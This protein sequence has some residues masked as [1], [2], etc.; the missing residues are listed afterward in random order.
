MFYWNGHT[1]TDAVQDRV[2]AVPV[3]HRE[4]WRRFKLLRRRVASQAWWPRN[5]S[6]VRCFAPSLPGLPR[7]R[8]PLLLYWIRLKTLALGPKAQPGLGLTR[9][10]ALNTSTHAK[11]CPNSRFLDEANSSRQTSFVGLINPNNRCLL[12]KRTM[13]KQQSGDEWMQFLMRHACLYSSWQATCWAAA[14][15]MKDK[16]E[17][18]C[19]RN[20][21][22][23]AFGSPF[24]DLK[25]VPINADV[26]V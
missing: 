13:D 23:D 24:L 20:S 12:L 14:A 2:T 25:H 8:L 16:W 21:K 3:L 1:D 10:A 4:T 15:E 5:C 19:K 17:T 26:P 11:I 9:L 18:I 22:S 6:Y 7:S